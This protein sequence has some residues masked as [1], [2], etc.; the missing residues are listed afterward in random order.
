M[1][2]FRSVAQH[3]FCSNTPVCDSLNISLLRSEIS[4][5]SRSIKLAGN[6]GEEC[7]YEGLVHRT[8]ATVIRL[9]ET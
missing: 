8:L 4:L 2:V 9:L 7:P 3:D 1:C 6:I 5:C